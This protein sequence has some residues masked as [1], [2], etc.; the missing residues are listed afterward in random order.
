VTGKVSSE[1]VKPVPVSFAALT[2]TEAVP[3]D[4]KVTDCVE[5]VFTVTSPKA[6]LVALRLSAGTAVEIVAFNCRMKLL[7]T[8]PAVAVSVAVCE[9][10]T[11]ATIAANSMLVALPGIVTV[12]GTVTAALLLDRLTLKPSLGAA[13]LSATVHVSVPAP[14]MDSLLQES[15]LSVAAV[16]AVT[17]VPLSAIVVVLLVE[18][19]LVMVN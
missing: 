11:Q 9:V 7:E 17:P 13:A 8:L 14:V 2:V 6:R 12:A 19:L 10:V 4:V 1:T 3:V 18:E 16:T 5:L 15:E